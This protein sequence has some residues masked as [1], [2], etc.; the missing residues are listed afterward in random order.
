MPS[1]TKSQPMLLPHQTPPSRQLSDSELVEACRLSPEA[2][3]NM[4]DIA[5]GRVTR[6]AMAA[7]AAFSKLS[8]L[9]HPAVAISR[10]P[11]ELAPVY[12]TIVRPQERHSLN[13]SDTADD[14]LAAPLKLVEAKVDAE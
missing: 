12:I 1:D 11:S 2:V 10:R 8:E 13:A 4:R 6:G 7:V 14:T 9:G 5:A 3:Q